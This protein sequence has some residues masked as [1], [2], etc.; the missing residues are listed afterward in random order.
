MSNL[1]QGH[2]SMT[3]VAFVIPNVHITTKTRYQA[4]NM[5]LTWIKL[6]GVS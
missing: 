1:M 5:S 6:K 4:T 2:L 3:A